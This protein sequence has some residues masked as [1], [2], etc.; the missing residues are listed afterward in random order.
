[1]KSIKKFIR[2]RKRKKILSPGDIVV[3]NIE[4][5]FRTKSTFT[6]WY[7][8]KLNAEVVD[9]YNTHMYLQFKE[10]ISSSS[11][12][13]REIAIYEKNILSIANKELHYMDIG[14]DAISNIIDRDHIGS[15]YWEDYIKEES[16]PDDPPSNNPI[17]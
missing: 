15:K 16:E 12:P 11:M 14:S 5:K 3:V 1:M 10:V 6:N 17:P 9:V 8:F 13:T 7:S 2:R 4:I